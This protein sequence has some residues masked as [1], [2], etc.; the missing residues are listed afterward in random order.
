M[1]FRTFLLQL[2]WLV[3]MIKLYIGTPEF[4]IPALEKDAKAAV[5]AGVPLPEFSGKNERVA[6]QA[7]KLITQTESKEGVVYSKEQREIYI[8]PDM[9][10]IYGQGSG[11]SNE[12]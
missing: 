5:L 12:L 6:L 7:Q 2:S 3:N 4:F 11:S 1:D 10:I 8:D 9:S